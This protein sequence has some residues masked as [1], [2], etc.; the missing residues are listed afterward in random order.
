[1]R[2]KNTY[3]LRVIGLTMVLCLSIASFTYLNIVDDNF[4]PP[5]EEQFVEEVDNRESKVLPDVQLIKM[6]M[7]KTLEFMT[8]TRQL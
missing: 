6:L 2:K 1:M 7:H 5:Q 8:Y 4:Q 3:R